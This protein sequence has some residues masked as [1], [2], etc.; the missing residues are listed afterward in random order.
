MPLYTKMFLHGVSLLHLVSVFHWHSLVVA[1][2]KKNP[3][4]PVVASKDVGT[5]DRKMY[6][7]FYFYFHFMTRRAILHNNS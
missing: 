1:R 4:L 5:G 6:F 2:H 7:Y 3:V